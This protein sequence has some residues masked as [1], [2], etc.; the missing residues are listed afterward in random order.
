MEK[1]KI[2][3]IIIIIAVI[4]IPVM[5]SFFYL[6]AFWDPY[7]NLKDIKVAIVNLDEGENG[8]NLGNELIDEL[9]ENDKVKF[10]FLNDSDEAQKGLINEE[11]YATITIPKE[12]TRDLNSSKELNK[13]AATITYSPN[14]KSN[15]LASQIINN[16][17]SEI[18]KNLRAEVSQKVVA[19]LSN[20]LKEV[21]NKMQTISDGAGQIQ[22]GSEELTNG[23]QT[24]NT[25]M[26]SLQS[27][28]EQFDSGVS[29][30]YN[31]SI[32]L[33]NGIITLNEGINKVTEGSNQL[34]NSTNSLS[35]ITSGVNSLKTGT[36]NL[37][38]GV[39]Q[40]VD[41]VN[42][43][44]NGISTIQSQIKTL[45]TDMQKYVSTN[46]EVTQD[47]N[48]QKIL[49]DLQKIQNSNSQSSGLSTLKN[50]GNELKQGVKNLNS[51]IQTFI[52]KA[53]QLETLQTG[54]TTLNNGVKQVQQGSEQL[55]QGSQTLNSGL[56]ELN[57]NSK[58]IYSGIEELN[59]G[60]NSA[61]EGSNKLKEGVNTF[62]SE[63]DSGIS[64]V[65]SETSKLEGLDEYVKEP[66]KIDE[67]D[68]AKVESYGVGFAPY[69]ISISLWVGALVALVMFYGDGE[70]RFKLLGKEAKNKYLRTI[71]Y[72]GIAATQ[73][74]VLGFLLKLGLGYNVTNIWLYYGIMILISMTFM[75]IE[76]FLIMNFGDIGK[77]LCILLLVLQLAASAGTFPIETVPTF[78]QAIYSFMPMNYTI[79][80]LKEALVQLN[81]NFVLYNAVIIFIIFIVFVTIT[82]ISYKIRNMKN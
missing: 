16:V 73:G 77:F 78:F 54:V 79:R 19:N 14:Q 34:A 55:K 38:S 53:N 70:K 56:N 67:K 40:Y 57:S 52:N 61:L 75:S 31:G 60:S 49:N 46:P 44:I 45:G 43:A 50:K 76:Q 23:L 74:I 35:S 48:F 69:F 80:L 30:A 28:Y 6:K 36:N 12:F 1:K 3:R 39:N 29:S 32:E 65:K 15:Y 26:N 27:N 2:M 22:N 68:Y 9:K 37:T 20:N 81:S 59:Y 58:K 10:V 13:R 7:G 8:Q 33:N 71:I 18:E 47:V 62:K 51:G 41:S 5:Y 24:L 25:G 4:I 66:V 63:I 42:S 72:L 82:N 21:P 11:Y 17:T 64:E